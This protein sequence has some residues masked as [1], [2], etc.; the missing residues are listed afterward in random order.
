MSVLLPLQVQIKQNG[1]SQSTVELGVLRG[2]LYVI[3]KQD[4]PE[5]RLESYSEDLF[6]WIALCRHSK[7]TKGKA[8]R[9]GVM[10]GWAG[11]LRAKSG[12]VRSDVIA[13]IGSA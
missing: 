13:L 10:D 7:A 12:K 1:I 9:V 2:A 3:A 4:S 6:W 5:Y 11:Q 8:K